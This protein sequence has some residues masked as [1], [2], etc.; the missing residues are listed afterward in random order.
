MKSTKE[1]IVAFTVE[2]ILKKRVIPTVPS[3]AG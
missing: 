1:P 3:A 2:T